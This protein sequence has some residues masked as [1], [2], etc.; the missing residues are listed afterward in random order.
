LSTQVE[1]YAV[2]IR[3][4]LPS[5]PDVAKAA[6]LVRTQFE[7]MGI[8]FSEDML[9]N[10][11][12]ARQIVAKELSD[13][14]VLKK[15]SIYHKHVEWYNG[16][17]IGSRFWPALEGYLLHT[18][19]WEQ[20]TVSRLDEES[21]EVVA[22]LAN[23]AL[24][25]ACYRGLVVGYV[26]SGKTANMTAV[27]SKAIDAGYNMVVV[28]AG[29]TNK[30]RQQTQAR[31]NSDLVERYPFDWQQLTS[32]D[33]NGDFKT[34]PSGY[35]PHPDN[36]VMLAVL[37]KNVSP[38][39][40]FLET[41]SDTP[42]I[43]RNQLRVL[44]ID[45]ECDSASVNSSS[46]ERD[47]TA[48]NE[49]IRRITKELTF[50]CYVGY[51]ATPFAN[52]LINPY[53]K[54]GELDDL[55]PQDFITALDLPTGYFGTA[56]LFGSDDD[57]DDEAT[58]LD[59]IRVVPDEDV[60]CLQPSSS[61]QKE[62]FYPV[63]PESLREAL[64]YF[65]AS[66]AARLARGHTS[67]HMTMLVHTSVLTDMHD[68]VS[69]LLEVELDRF[70]DAPGRLK[71]MWLERMRR[72]WE[73]E[74]LRVPSADFDSLEPISFDQLAAYLPEVLDRIE[75][76]VE[77]GF[78]DNRISYDQEPKIYVVVGGTVLARGLTL[79]GL[80]VSYFLRSTN[81]YDTLL[82]MGRWFGYRKGYEDLPRI[83]M[84][85][86]L[87][88]SFR[89]LAGV[90]A[91]IR[92]DIKQYRERNITPRDLA[93]RI[94][95]LPG[96]KITSAAKMK[97]A[98]ICKLDY[99]GQHRQTIRFYHKDQKI[100]SGNWNAAAN[101]FAV[102]DSYRVEDSE[103]ILFRNVPENLVRNF[104]HRYHVHKDHKELSSEFLLGHMDEGSSA[105]A[106]WN[107]GFFQPTPKETVKTSDKTVGKIGHVRMVNR[108]RLGDGR[109]D[110]AD[111]KGLMSAKDVLFDCDEP[112]PAD[113][114][115]GW[116]EYKA[117]RART[118]NKPLLLLY[119]VDKD[120]RPVGKNSERKP[121]DAIED[122]IAFGVVF[123]G[124]KGSSARYVSVT[125]DDY[126]ADEPAYSESLDEADDEID[127]ENL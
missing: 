60:A 20:T 46:K 96:M 54:H 100:L 1:A 51:T 62:T 50:N 121:L 71:P 45:D 84:T 114:K 69:S 43:V 17:V 32:S 11:D 21:S 49:L 30:L 72:V 59:M 48:I 105:G 26:Q 31:L 120:S 113:A 107:I 98:E 67:A 18:K 89:L 87:K 94:V 19:G 109:E 126:S 118:E 75:T 61:K 78:S 41:I 111:I 65:I 80:T 85:S 40:R 57:A 127:G 3:K 110:M 79:E 119:C 86:D 104:F 81:Q 13:L 83:W 28:L 22:M 93:V 66:C 42:A 35:L 106:K 36:G 4:N 82:Q 64:L 70:V 76:P 115:K 16:P 125:L 39:K 14:H 101:L 102:L 37:K 8:P 38:L 77:N 2:Q 90:E 63:I 58:G 74:A 27:I 95:D 34:P 108:S 9:N 124:D 97:H 122:I 53:G 10:L 24:A 23:P 68:R 99:S 73:S 92:D 6:S 117:W 25:T 12:L 44:I 29:L 56:Q 5:I 112:F 52:V 103:Q 47:M 55:Y 116:T 88:L 15:R 7:D 123:P 33:Y 91:E